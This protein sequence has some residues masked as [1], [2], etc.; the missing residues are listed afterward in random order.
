[1]NSAQLLQVADLSAVFHTRRGPVRAVDGVSFD[2]APGETL[3]VVGESGSGKTVMSRTVLHLQPG[4]GL[5]S[6]GAVLFDGTDLSRLSTK[7]MRSFWGARIGLVPQDPMTSLNP[8][9]RLG[10]QLTEHVQRHLGLDRRAA[11][12]RA[13]ELLGSVGISDP[14]RRL[15]QYPY[16]LSGGMRQRVAIAIAIACGPAL[17]VADEPT[18]ALDV[19]VQAQILDLLAHQQ[20]ERKM[21]MLLIS[22]DLAV[23]AGR[24]DHTMVM[25]AG[26]VVEKSETSR[27]FAAPRHP[28]TEALLAATPRVDA[29]SHTRHR[30]IPG[31]PPNLLDLG[32]GCRFAP[33]CRYAQDEC[34]SQA[35]GL[36]AAGEPGHDA[37]CFFPV[38]TTEGAEALRANLRR[39]RTAA[40][41]PISDDEMEGATA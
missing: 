7:Q 3:G 39:G 34:L 29:P 27:L 18:T 33:R 26:Q 28:Y 22:H 35:P 30:A 25:Y 32:E 13:V 11:D 15:R 9:M 10:R 20:R 6:G 37:R 24:T 41:S 31:R 19:T 4:L 1:V 21:S 40:G 16:E 8:V 36:V 38:G 17:L 5:G 12:T 14:V 23:V 2:L